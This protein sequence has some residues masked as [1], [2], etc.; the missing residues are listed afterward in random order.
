MTSGAKKHI[1]ADEVFLLSLF[2]SAFA[3]ET[4]ESLGD[5]VPERIC[6]ALIHPSN[7][8]SRPEYD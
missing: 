7:D 6:I 8:I 4:S 2:M 5:L 3:S 1:K